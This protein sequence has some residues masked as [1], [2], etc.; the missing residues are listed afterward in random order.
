MKYPVVFAANNDYIQH[1]SVALLSLLENNRG[2]PFEIYLLNEGL[3]SENK[4]IVS[5]KGVTL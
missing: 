1:F 3:S 5:V 4:S 2:I